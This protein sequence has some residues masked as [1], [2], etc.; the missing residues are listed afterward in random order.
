MTPMALVAERE[1]MELSEWDPVDYE[2]GE[3]FDGI[4]DEY[5]DVLEELAAEQRTER[6]NEIKQCHRAF[7][8]INSLP[9]WH[10]R[11]PRP[12]HRGRVTFLGRGP[13]P[14]LVLSQDQ[15][16]RER[17]LHRQR[18]RVRRLFGSATPL[19]LRASTD[20]NNAYMLLADALGAFESWGGPKADLHE[21][22][23]LEPFVAK[24]FQRLKSALGLALH[25]SLL[26][27]ARRQLQSALQLITARDRPIPARPGELADHDPPGQIVLASPHV[28]NGPPRL[29]VAALMRRMEAIPS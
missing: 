2:S 11:N 9:L 1:P 25:K 14:S 18:R 29:H 26:D 22:D 15:L 13:R 6:F 24:A 17:S 3:G 19:L 23:R 27:R 12:S 20:A 21:F 8:A 4:R 5:G 16:D 7:G 28:I 10:R